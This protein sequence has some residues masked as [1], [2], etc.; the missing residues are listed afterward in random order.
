MKTPSF[1]FS[2][3]TLFAAAGVFSAACLAGTVFTP[4][5]MAGEGT[6]YAVDETVTESGY[7]YFMN[8]DGYDGIG[9]LVYAMGADTNY[10]GTNISIGTSGNFASDYG[11]YGIWVVTDNAGVTA[12]AVLQGGSIATAGMGS[13]GVYVER[14]AAELND[15]PITTSG[16]AAIGVCA[17][18]DSVQPG[19][20]R[21]NNSN[22]TTTSN[23]R[24]AHAVWADAGGVIVVAGTSQIRAV[25]RTSGFTF[26]AVAIRGGVV[27]FLDNQQ[28]AGSRLN[29]SSDGKIK[30]S[31]SSTIDGAHV[32]LEGG[33]LDI[34]ASTGNVTIATMYAQDGS[35]IDLGANKLILDGS[36][37]AA[38]AYSIQ[39]AGE[40]TL[41]VS[42]DAAGNYGAI[43]SSLAIGHGTLVIDVD[44]S[45]A[46][47][48][49]GVAM[50]VVKAAF[51]L[52]AGKIE[53]KVNG[54]A[55]AAGETVE[56]NG[57]QITVG[58]A[59]GGF[60]FT[61]IPEPSTYAIFGGIL[62]LGL[63]ALARRRRC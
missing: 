30:I 61:V 60:G 53:Y 20:V 50:E 24:D 55:V 18:G 51:G 19:Y 39:T 52:N 9:V 11:A 31:G 5:A 28:Q 29:A 41:K 38:L 13:Y 62:A 45:Q 23:V 4:A 59:G 1:A 17:I 25:E 33:I 27:E 3:K 43:E 2:S 47:L 16:A 22:V 7:S 32:N 44:L 40:V 10:V 36:L 63:C 42:V 21:L 49:D 26:D 48:Q 58:A 35:T 8:E 12:G 34:S 37:P 46:L 54:V 15:T 57:K 6:G 56:V 14:A